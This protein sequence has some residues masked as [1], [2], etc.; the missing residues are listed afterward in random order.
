MLITVLLTTTSFDSLQ[1]SKPEGKKGPQLSIPQVNP[2]LHSLSESQSPS[3]SVHGLVLV[4]Q[5]EL[6]TALPQV[7]DPVSVTVK[8]LF[9]RLSMNH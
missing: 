6:D 5:V 9:A 3:P 4:Q 2:L 8:C 1:Q 7:S